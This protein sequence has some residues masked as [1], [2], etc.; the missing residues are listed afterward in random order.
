MIL[1][2]LGADVIK[3]ENPR[4]GDDSRHWGPPYAHG[5]AAYFLC[6]NRNKKSVAVDIA[7]SQGQRIVRELAATAD[8]VVENYKFGALSKF[9]LD[10][11]SLCAVH[12]ALIYCSISGYGRDSILADRSGYDFVIQAEGGLM[13][14]T[15]ER[16]GQPMKV[17]V[18]VADLFTGM[19]AAQAILAALVALDRDGVGQHIDMALFDSQLAMLANVGSAFLTS[20]EEPSRYGNAHPTVVPYELFAT[21]DG[22]VVVAVG[23]DRQFAALCGLL[24]RLDLSS[25]DRFATNAGRVSNRVALLAVLQ[26]LIA[27]RTTAFWL[28]AL[29]SAGIPTGEVRSVGSALN[30]PEA[31][32]RNMI[33]QTTYQ[34]G[35]EISLVGSPLK[36]S[37]TPVVDPIAPPLLGEHTDAVLKSLLSYNESTIAQLRTEQVIA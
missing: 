36:L 20:G 17:G 5:E 24:G 10:Y 3:I 12:P 25:D 1:A 7:T 11:D 22:N 29:Q 33:R 34:S 27:H 31:A 21:V 19:A 14:I 4:G 16:D 8:V 2:D 23:N 35:H 9:G 30:S 32:A 26:P 13:A 37:R 28:S 18:A 6:T 15:G